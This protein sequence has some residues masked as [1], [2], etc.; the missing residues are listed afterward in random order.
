MDRLQ[1]NIELA[2]KKKQEN[3]KFIKRLKAK[4]PRDLDEVTLRLHETAFS[5]INC[6][7]CARCCKVL[8]PRIT[9]KDID[10]IAKF[11]NM[12]PDGFIHK[13]LRIDEDR[14]YVFQSM[15]CPF[16]REDNYCS[17]YEVRPKACAEYPH[18]DRRKIHQILDLTFKNS[19]TCPAVYEIVEGLKEQ[20]TR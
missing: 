16:L 18:T 20:Y 17:V 12:K 2:Q 14:D 6:L 9:L 13:Y 4:K 5:H 8:G 19:L 11:L 10:R 7:D 15:P 3:Q 1:K